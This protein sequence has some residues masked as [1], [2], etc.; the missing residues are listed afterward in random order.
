MLIRSSKVSDIEEGGTFSVEKRREQNWKAGN[1]EN[2][3]TSK[4]N[5]S[6]RHSAIAEI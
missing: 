2:N 5:L 3:V 6:L 1:G 4:K